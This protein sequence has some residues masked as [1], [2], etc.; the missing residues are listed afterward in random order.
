MLKV[1][2][3]INIQAR[4]LQGTQ[5]APASRSAPLNP[6]PSIVGRWKTEPPQRVRENEDE[7]SQMKRKEEYIFIETDCLIREG[8][9]D[10][11]S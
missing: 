4:P 3:I 9:K 8:M 7:E 10:N 2:I 1:G 11:K 5:R 6:P